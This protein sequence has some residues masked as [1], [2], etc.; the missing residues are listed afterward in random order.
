MKVELLDSGELISPQKILGGSDRSVMGG[1]GDHSPSEFR[2][3]LIIASIPR[4]RT[5]DIEGID[6]DRICSS[7]RSPFKYEFQE[8]QTRD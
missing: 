8:R 3:L 5:I 1:H 6:F 7:Q 2:R 4:G